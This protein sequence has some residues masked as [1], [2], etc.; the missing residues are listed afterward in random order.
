M[1]TRLR[2]ILLPL[3]V[4]TSILAFI[5]WLIFR[6][7]SEDLPRQLHAP[8]IIVLT[9]GW[10]S[11]P[12]GLIFSHGPWRKR[13]MPVTKFTYFWIGFF[14]LS[15]SFILVQLVISLFVDHGHS[16]WPLIAA[17]LASVWSIFRALGP[18]RI[19]T[20]ELSG[21][22]AMNG[23]TLVQISDLHVG[24]PFLNKKWLARQVKRINELR[25]DFVAVTGDLADGPFEEIAPA[26]APL[27]DLKPAKRKFYVTGNHEFI[28]G[29]D[30]EKRL[31][32]LGFTVLHNTHEIFH[33]P[34]G[35]F[36]IA[37]VPDRVIF[38]RGSQFESAP[39][40]ALA[41]KEDVSYR[42]LLAH[43][44]KSVFNL[45]G[46]R[47]DLLLSGHTHGGQIFPFAI[48]VRLVQ[49]VVRGFKKIDGVLVFAHMGTGF[50]G[51][52]MRWLT[53]SEIVRFRWTVG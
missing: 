16:Y 20:H 10:L 29:G 32:E 27:A 40:K 14:F 37:G 52:P 46:E 43:E 2:R 1:S 50:W 34:G 33:T 4:I 53:I 22:S 12:L 42:I 8:M 49:P 13:L 31:R 17:A 19:I 9:L 35:R 47:C 7:T 3:T 18:P 15:F 51:P 45:G 38:S 6:V 44:P 21:P 28:R 36:M 23:V 39:H 48:F 26:L 30:W 25:P 24:M 5:H 11:I 41:T